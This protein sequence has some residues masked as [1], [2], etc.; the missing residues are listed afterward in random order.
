MPMTVKVDVM[1]EYERVLSVQESSTTRSEE[2][3]E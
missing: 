1:R 2:D 3:P